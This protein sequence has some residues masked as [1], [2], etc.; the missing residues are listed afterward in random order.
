VTDWV[1]VDGGR[2]RV[3]ARVVDEDAEPVMPSWPGLAGFAG[4]VIHAGTFRNAAEM[5]GLDVLVVGPGNSG[6]DLLGYQ[7]P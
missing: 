2:G 6:V 5:A 4:I 3:D 7:F 1:L